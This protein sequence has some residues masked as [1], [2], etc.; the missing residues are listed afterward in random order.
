MLGG[1]HWGIANYSWHSNDVASTVMAYKVLSNEPAQKSECQSIIQYFLEKRRNGFWANTVES[2][3]ILDA[4]LPDILQQQKDF[5]QPVAVKITGDTSFVISSFPYKTTCSSNIKNISID[6]TGGGM[7]YFTAYQHF[8]NSNPNAVE[9]KF[10]ISTSFKQSNQQKAVIKTG[11]RA[12]MQV[13]VN[14]LKDAEYVQIEIP[15]PAG[16]TYASKEN[17]N[18]RFIKAYYKNKVLLFAETLSSGIH[19]FEIELV[20]TYSGSFTINPA[21]ASLMYFPVFYG[22][23]ELRKTVIRD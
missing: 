20:P 8:F 19:H 15:I 3:S 11:E 6:K 13:T 2:A 14:V 18:W 4:I 17:S 5:N 21:K 22:R 1:I 10:V 12:T 23:N 9:D 7:V 16:C